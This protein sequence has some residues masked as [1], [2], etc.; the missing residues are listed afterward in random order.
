MVIKTH[1]PVLKI[2]AAGSLPEWAAGQRGRA[3]QRVA[4][5]SALRGSVII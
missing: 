1:I 4:G 3:D 2:A 5:S